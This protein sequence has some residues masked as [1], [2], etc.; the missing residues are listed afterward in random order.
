MESEGGSCTL[1]LRMASAI[2]TLPD[3]GLSG[4]TARG[5]WAETS[6]V[7]TASKKIAPAKEYFQ[8]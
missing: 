8:N 5:V 2:S 7:P 3:F 4:K 6:S 1:P